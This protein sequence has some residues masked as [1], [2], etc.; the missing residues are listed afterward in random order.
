VRRLSFPRVKE[1]EQA[2]K[3]YP[4]SVGAFAAGMKNLSDF[5]FCLS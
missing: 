1:I 5:G 4:A 2:G 3:D